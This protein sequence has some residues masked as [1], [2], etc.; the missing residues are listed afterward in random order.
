[1]AKVRNNLLL[2]GLS[3]MLGKQL[4][5][6]QVGDDTILSMAP[7]KSTKP[8][9]PRQ[10]A[11]EEQFGEATRYAQSRAADPLMVARFAALPRKPHTSVHTMLIAD[12]RCPPTVAAL[13]L[14]HYTGRPGEPLYITALDNY[15]V[16]SVHVRLT[17]P[18]GR[19]VEEGPA[20]PGSAPSLWC[21]LTTAT[22]ATRTGLRVSATATD[23]PGHTGSREALL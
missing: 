7:A 5:F 14:S 8:R 16:Q 6:R 15:G 10:L 23:Y 12:F 11:Q 21:Y 9:S 22:V 3:G 20:Q 4:V 18:D 1:M 19:V 13:D 17:A 2:R